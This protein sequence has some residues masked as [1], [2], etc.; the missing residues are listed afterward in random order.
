MRHPTV[1]PATLALLATLLLAACGPSSSDGTPPAA[2]GGTIDNPDEAAQFVIAS[3][4]RF[5]AL[6]LR[7]QDPELIG[8]C[9]WYEATAVEGGYE[10]VI[11]V[12]WGDCPAGCINE[13]RWTYAVTAD[14]GVTPAGESGA[15][16]PPGPLP[17]ADGI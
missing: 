17:P 16:V 1:I 8:G 5:A 7:P 13:H 2:S 14:G 12:G 6:E 10:V 15:P 3:D 4:P 9:C 11:R